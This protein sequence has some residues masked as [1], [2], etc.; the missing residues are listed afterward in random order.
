MQ[1]LHPRADQRDF[2]NFLLGHQRLGVIAQI[3]QNQ[4]NVKVAAV[5]GNVDRRLIRHVLKPLHR[6]SAP[7]SA[8]HAPGPGADRLSD[9]RVMSGPVARAHKPA[10][11][12]TAG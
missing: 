10:G 5:V 9:D 11:L 1:L 2:A 12:K 3:A 4:G 6:D 7:G 8:D